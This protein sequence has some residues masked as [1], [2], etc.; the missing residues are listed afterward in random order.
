MT[1]PLPK[2]AMTPHTAIELPSSFAALPSS[3]DRFAAPSHATPRPQRPP[4]AG[5][6]VVGPRAF[7]VSDG[8]GPLRPA[9]DGPLAVDAEGYIVDRAQGRLLGWPLAA[10]DNAQRLPRPAPLR[11]GLV[12]ARARATRQVALT[13]N[14]DARGL[15]LADA[16]RDPA[17]PAGWQHAL[18][19]TVYD[20]QGRALPLVGGLRKT[21]AD[22]WLVVFVDGDGRALPGTPWRLRFDADSGQVAPGC[23]AVTVALGGQRIRLDFSRATQTAAPFAV[24]ELQQDGRDALP[25][26]GVTI[27]S[28]GV[29]SAHYEGG[30]CMRIGRA[31]H[32]AAA[33]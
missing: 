6:A 4:A 29:V 32:G 22:E 14:L 31:R 11:A 13:L 16:P 30:G 3:T 25:L 10:G 1:T 24:S 19:L 20:A 2:S 9:A 17:H 5:V 33:R 27:D 18:S 23:A 26:H 8:R 21:A 28:S 12:A 15:P 7:L